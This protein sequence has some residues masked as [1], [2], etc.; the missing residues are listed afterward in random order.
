MENEKAAVP[1]IK[2]VLTKSKVIYRCF[3]FG[4]ITKSVDRLTTKM[5]RDITIPR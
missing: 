1:Q 4:I 2:Y 5:E 3:D